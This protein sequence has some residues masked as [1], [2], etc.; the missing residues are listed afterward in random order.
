MLHPA[1]DE[2][3]YRNYSE[4]DFQ[5][6]QVIKLLRSMEVS[7]DDIK[8]IINGQ[9]NIQEC[10]KTQEAYL[11]QSMD[12]LQETKKVVKILK[13][14]EIPVIPAL[15]DIEAIEVPWSM[16]YRKTT[17]TVTIGR[18]LTR[19]LLIRNLITFV[20]GGIAIALASYF[21]FKDSV[22]QVMV[23][24]AITI[25]IVFIF[26]EILGLA[27]GLG[28]LKTVSIESNPMNFIEFNYEG[29]SFYKKG[30]ITKQIK[31]FV[32]ILKG[33]DITTKI[34]YEEI[35]KVTITKAV[36]YMKIPGSNLSTDRQAKDYTFYFTSGDKYFIRDAIILENDQEY[37]DAIL[38]E[39]VK[40][41][42]YSN[43]K[44]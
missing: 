18:K 3:K 25:G 29:I 12:T 1:R 22:G 14:K 13:E 10:L 27:L 17:K 21:G 5:V 40:N 20:V 33:Q 15:L 4:E 31:Y 11:Q 43:V 9:L 7:I 35:S 41:I 6:L 37:I 19:P 44:K 16:G 2:N 42:E 38:Q 8:L 32:A 39:K 26:I 34:P 23:V 24:I 28:V 30:S 36:R